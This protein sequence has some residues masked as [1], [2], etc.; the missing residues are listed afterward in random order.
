MYSYMYC[1]TYSINNMSIGKEIFLCTNRQ[2]SEK[3][4]AGL[5]KPAVQEALSFHEQLP[6]YIP[7]PLVPLQALSQKLGLSQLWCK[8]ES[9]RFGLNAYK[10]LGGAY[11]IA[12]ILQQRLNLK[13]LSY[14]A[15]HA[16]QHP[17]AK[18]K[19]V[20][21][22]ATDGNHGLGV[23]YIATKLG[24][25]AHIYVPQHMVESRKKA[26]EKAGGQLTVFPGGYDD[27][28]RQVALDAQKFRWQVIADTA[29]EGYNQVPEWIMEGYTTIFEEARQQLHRQIPTHIF[30][31]AGV[32]S[33][34]ASLC[35]YIRTHYTVKPP[36][37]IITEPLGAACFFKSAQMNDG[38]AHVHPGE[39]HTMMAGLACA[40]P[41]P[42][43]WPIIRDCANAMLSCSDEVSALGMKMYYRPELPDRQIIS[44]ESGSVTLGALYKVMTGKAYSDIR[45]SLDLNQ[46]AKVLL[47]NTEGATDPDNFMKVV[48]G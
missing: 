23:A 27:A 43:A 46:H 18:N 25:H 36:R 30:I 48:Q 29:W 44:G 7:T 26:I 41:N 33:L 1:W 5:R 35:R 39:V 16:D 15:L 19:L 32:G 21:A 14:S 28:V 42:L 11:A 10:A 47:I 31:Q 40:E 6:E 8:D 3:V 13:S 34:A 12:R 37:I 22:T 4:C 20:F 45:A 17:A 38:S 9:Y 24:Y 2:F